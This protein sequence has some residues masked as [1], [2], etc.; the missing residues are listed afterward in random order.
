MQD[1]D[2]INNN[3]SE[4]SFDLHYGFETECDDRGDDALIT[5]HERPKAP[6]PMILESLS[7]YDI[8]E[9]LGKDEESQC[10]TV[11]PAEMAGSNHCDQVAPVCTNDMTCSKKNLSNR[12]DCLVLEDIDDSDYMDSQVFVRSLFIMQATSQDQLIDDS[13]K[14]NE[15]NHLG[16]V[17][18]GI[19]FSQK[20]ITTSKA[21]SG[22]QS[23]RLRRLAS[24]ITRAMSNKF[25]KLRR[26]TRLATDVPSKTDEKCHG[27]KDTIVNGSMSTHNLL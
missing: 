9:L 22:S 3:T 4:V 11:M 14:P 7:N 25:R 10:V 2:G 27:H 6:E 26:P 21:N 18:E 17:K 24:T 1:A 19:A 20:S 12:N 16:S 5:E 13:T 23:S 15:N 8:G